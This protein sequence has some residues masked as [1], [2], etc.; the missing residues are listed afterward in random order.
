MK[1]L[2]RLLI[3]ATA[4]ACCISHHAWAADGKPAAATASK[5][6][7]RILQELA[8]R[9]RLQVGKMGNYETLQQDYNQPNAEP[10]RSHTFVL[11]LGHGVEVV[12]ERHI[13]DHVLNQKDYF[14]HESRVYAYRVIRHDPCMDGKT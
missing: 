7:P 10:P 1:L 9:H 11:R 2:P 5:L 8:N 12:T 13:E 14:I 3:L 6:D 4:A